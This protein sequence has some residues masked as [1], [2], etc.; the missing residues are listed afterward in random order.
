MMHVVPILLRINGV[1]IERVRLRNGA[2]H[3]VEVLV[4]DKVVGE[5]KLHDGFEIEALKGFQKDSGGW[6]RVNCGQLVELLR[7]AGPKGADA[8]PIDRSGWLQTTDVAEARA[9]AASDHIE[10]ALINT[11]ERRSIRRFKT[12][13]RSLRRAARLLYVAEIPFYLFSTYSP[14]T[15]EAGAIEFVVR[16]S[17][18]ATDWFAANNYRIDA[19]RPFLVIDPVNETQIRFIQGSK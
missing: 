12:W 2:G 10:E 16:N 14:R 6:H 4:T 9:F 15:D 7:S 3:D 17:A 11:T 18:A 8:E 5:F 19:A 1:T 13:E